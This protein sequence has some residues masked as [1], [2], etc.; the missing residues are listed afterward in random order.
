MAG[1][2]TDGAFVAFVAVFGF[3][4]FGE[5]FDLSGGIGACGGGWAL[6]FD[7]YGVDVRVGVIGEDVAGFGDC[8]FPA[9]LDLEDIRHCLVG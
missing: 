2:F 6:E 8:L 9:Y 7:A 5:D 4:W 1:F 3:C